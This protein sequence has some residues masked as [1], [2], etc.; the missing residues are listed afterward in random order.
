MQCCQLL[1]IYVNYSEPC[2]CEKTYSKQDYKSCNV[3]ILWGHC[4]VYDILEDQKVKGSTNVACKALQLQYH[5]NTASYVFLAYLYFFL[6]IIQS[7]LYYVS[8]TAISYLSLYIC[9][10]Y[11]MNKNVIVQQCQC[12]QLFKIVQIWLWQFRGRADYWNSKSFLT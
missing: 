12:C 5:T 7:F 8:T 10:R 3:I 6:I 2:W 4:F 1:T 9:W 11:E